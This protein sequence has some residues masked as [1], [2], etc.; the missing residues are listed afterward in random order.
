[1]RR[2]GHIILLP[3]LQQRAKVEAVARSGIAFAIRK[4]N[5]LQRGTFGADALH[6]RQQLGSRYHGH[7]T[8]IVEA[9]ANL[10]FKKLRARR[11]E[12]AAQLGNGK[13]RKVKLG[14]VRQPE[15]DTVA[16]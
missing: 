16:A 4:D 3:L 7:R 6:G 1:M 11:D 9:I 14:P 15:E 10:G 12:H 5:V 13:S 2:S 8:G